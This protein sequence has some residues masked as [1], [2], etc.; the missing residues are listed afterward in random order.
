MLVGVRKLTSQI[1]IRLPITPELL[2]LLVQAVD[3]GKY[4][5]FMCHV[6]VAYFLI[7]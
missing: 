3:P 6:G 5:I 2:K 7:D 1:D 4:K